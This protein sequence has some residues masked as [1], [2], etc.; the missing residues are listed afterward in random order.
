MSQAAFVVLL[1]GNVVAY[2]SALGHDSLS[3]VSLVLYVLSYLVSCR[4]SRAQSDQLSL[5]GL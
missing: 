2:A 4:F 3:F 5:N 1:A